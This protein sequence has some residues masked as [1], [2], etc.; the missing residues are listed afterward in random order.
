[1][2]PAGKSSTMEGKTKQAVL[3]GVSSTEE[4]SNSVNLECTKLDQKSEVLEEKNQEAAMT[5][6]HIQ[7]FLLVQV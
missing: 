6:A 1:M 2:I 5:E 4:T 7:V 3:Y